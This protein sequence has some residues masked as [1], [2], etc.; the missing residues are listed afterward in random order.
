MRKP[1]PVSERRRP[2][3]AETVSGRGAQA[4]ARS[5]A[6]VRALSAAWPDEDHLQRLRLVHLLEQP[7]HIALGGDAVD[8][9]HP[10]HG[11]DGP[12]AG[13]EVVLVNLPALHHLADEEGGTGRRIVDADA[14]I[15][16]V[17][18]L[19]PNGEGLGPPDPDLQV[20]TLP[21]CFQH[22]VDADAHAGAVDAHDEVAHLQMLVDVLRAAV[23]GVCYASGVDAA[24]LWQCVLVDVEVNA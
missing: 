24:H 19:D 18:P 15:A 9:H 20:G 22:L 5:P 11:L 7:A 23:V 2:D 16:L 8:G 12:W 4:T 1:A 21:D 17:L 3:G 13:L 14:K 10:V 6:P